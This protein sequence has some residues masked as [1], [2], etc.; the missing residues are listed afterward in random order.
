[1]EAIYHIVGTWKIYM[2]ELLLLLLLSLK[3]WKD[4]ALLTPMVTPRHI[5]LICCTPGQEHCNFT[6]SRSKYE[7]RSSGPQER[8]GLDRMWML[9]H[10]IR[11]ENESKKALLLTAY[12]SY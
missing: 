8:Q 11:E 9:N 1:M 2:K 12:L 10:S 3:L 7:R 6:T 5:S 4:L